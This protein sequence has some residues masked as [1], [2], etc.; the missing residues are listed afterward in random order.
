MK[1][2]PLIA[3]P[4]LAFILIIWT[5]SSTAGVANYETATARIISGTPV[6][7]AQPYTWMVSFQSPVSGSW[8]HYCGGT[9]IAAD[10][11]ITA[12]HCVEN[13]D[14]SNHRGVFGAVDLTDSG[15]ERSK[16]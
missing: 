14:M 9:L 11:V 6:N 1:V 8:G 15:Q 16:K 3:N 13:T 2:K 4:I 10:W 12:A 5:L 7:S